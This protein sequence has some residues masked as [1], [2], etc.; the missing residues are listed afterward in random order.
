MF[1]LSFEIAPRQKQG[2][3][4]FVPR[5]SPT[6][7]NTPLQWKLYR[8]PKLIIITKNKDTLLNAIWWNKI[9]I[10]SLKSRTI[11]TKTELSCDQNNSKIKQYVN[12]SE[13]TQW[14]T[15]DFLSTNQHYFPISKSAESCRMCRRSAASGLNTYIFKNC[16]CSVQ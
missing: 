6:S 10:F 4:W 12:I 2:K 5:Q 7:I 14:H 13:V 15:W 8:S 3:R 11:C 9:Y 1:W 16:T